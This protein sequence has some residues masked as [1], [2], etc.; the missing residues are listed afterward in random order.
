MNNYEEIKSEPVITDEQKAD[1]DSRARNID[2]G[3]YSLDGFTIIRFGIP[4]QLLKMTKKDAREFA[5]QIVKVS[6]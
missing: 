1:I 2:I 6:L 3:I 5:R 4:R